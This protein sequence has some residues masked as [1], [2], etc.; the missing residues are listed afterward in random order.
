MEARAK[1]SVESTGARRPFRSSF[2]VPILLG[3]VVLLNIVN[4][5][6][7]FLTDDFLFLEH[8]R[9]RPGPESLFSPDPLG[10]YFRPLSR[11]VYFT[12]LG[13]ASGER[14]WVFRLFNLACFLGAIVLVF[15]I[16]RRL[17][18]ELGGM[19]AATFFGFHY[20]TLVPLLWI[21][22]CQDL[23]ATTLGLMC[24]D[25]ALSGRWVISSAALALALLSKESAVATPVAVVV[26][27]WARDCHL[28]RALRSSAGLWLVLALWVTVWLATLGMRPARPDLDVR[29]VGASVAAALHLL[30]VSLGLEFRGGEQPFG[31][32]GLLAPMIALGSGVLIWL[33]GASPPPLPNPQPTAAS[34]RRV[35]IGGVIWALAS[36]APLVVVLSI[37]SAYFY[38]F[39]LCGI[40]VALGALLSRSRRIVAAGIVGILVLLSSQAGQ[41]DEFS[42]Q[43]SPWTWRS[44]IN[45]H[46]LRRAMDLNS[47]YLSALK[48]AR[49]ALPHGSTIFFA[50]VPVSAGWQAGNGALVRWAYRDTSLRSYFLGEFDKSRAS[51]G[52]LFFFSVDGEELIDHS[53]DPMMLA[54]F[55]FS[56]LLAD[57]PA[58]ACDALDLVL[59]RNPKDAD[60]HQWRG[61]ARLSN[62]DTLGAFADLR[63]GGISPVFSSTVDSTAGHVTAVQ[64]TA[65]RITALLA[66]RSVAGLSPQVHARLAALCLQTI[67][68]QQLGVIEAYAYR[69]LSPDSPDAWRK[70]ASAQISQQQFDA[71]LRSLEHYQ[72]LIGRENRR[73]A[74][75]D[76]VIDTL[77]RTLYGD[78]AQDALHH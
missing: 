7:P 61:W 66:A 76:R 27:L 38:L 33:V 60:F 67:K 71:G 35:A 37:W 22:G 45:Y 5:R 57:Q 15:R 74:E 59:E 75:V 21:S 43:R 52:Q 77:R 40:A 51:R 48:S 68:L 56:M 19:V 16:V 44:H 9:V 14:P 6:Q 70:W 34:W 49:P 65:Q 64:D 13:A 8:A 54:S 78:L 36:T 28:R 62:R 29:W 58:R 24:I 41:L 39:A 4:L 50:N 11:Q 47:R 32:W 20:A 53:D 3:C 42:I 69:V 46:H 63:E 12:L 55:A 17:I 72:R 73:D 1:A 31:H 26:L 18:G 10:N 2:L 25:L 23:L 30:Q